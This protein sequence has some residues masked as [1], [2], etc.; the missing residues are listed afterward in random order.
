VQQ[1]FKLQIAQLLQGFEPANVWSCLLF[2]SYSL[3]RLA[4]RIFSYN[5]IILPSSRNLIQMIF[6]ITFIV[7]H[8]VALIGRYDRVFAG[9]GLSDIDNILLRALLRILPR[10]F[11][12]CM[13][14]RRRPISGGSFSPAGKISGEFRSHG[15]HYKPGRPSSHNLKKFRW[16]ACLNCKQG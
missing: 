7:P 9:H 2:K 11:T 13:P 1:A 12:G 10:D 14:K 3:E 6:C 8:L 5:F 16:H 4:I 15:R